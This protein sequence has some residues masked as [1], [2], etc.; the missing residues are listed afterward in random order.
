M[1]AA[2]KRI[3]L[4]L[5]LLPVL[6]IGCAHAPARD[7]HARPAGA[8][9]IH[10]QNEQFDG[11]LVDV[12]VGGAAVRLGQV[13]GF[14]TRVFVLPPGVAVTS[15]LALRATRRTSEPGQ[16]SPT[17]DLLDGTSVFWVLHARPALSSLMVR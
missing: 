8:I 7:G 13:D 14:G 10:V 16:R 6:V 15:P 9:R 3:L 5:R 17:F 1:R 4:L 12:L 11:V 2:S